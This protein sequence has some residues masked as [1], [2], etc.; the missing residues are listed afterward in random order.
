M[1]KQIVAAA[2][3]SLAAAASLT[4]LQGPAQAQELPGFREVKRQLYPTSGRMSEL[5]VLKDGFLSANQVK[6][7]GAAVAKRP[8]FGAIALSPSAGVLGKGA[9]MVFNFHSASDAHAAA[10]S[11]CESS[12]AD[13]A[14][15][16]VV[17][18]DVVPRGYRNPRALEMN[19]GAAKAFRTE[20]RKLKGHRAFALSHAAGEWGFAGGAA[21][22]EAAI[23]AAVSAC[24]ERAAPKGGTDCAAVSA[25]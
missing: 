8:Y 2:L 11:G 4:A 25:D 24:A 3:A 21:S 13:D 18:A 12:R 6:I 14:E 15:R 1:R 19:A 7:I 22:V 23:Q 16:C 5:R 17:I 10:L 9:T 20:Y